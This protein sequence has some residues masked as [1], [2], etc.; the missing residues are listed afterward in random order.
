MSYLTDII[1][2][3]MTF[4][5]CCSSYSK[6]CKSSDTVCLDKQHAYYETLLSDSR[7]K[8]SNKIDFAFVFC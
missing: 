4:T 7:E 8:K 3:D 1:S 2:N 5:E 6:E